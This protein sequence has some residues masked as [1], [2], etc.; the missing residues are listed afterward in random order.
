M[1]KEDLHLCCSPVYREATLTGKGTGVA[2]ISDKEAGCQVASAATE[3]G[4][5]ARAN[6]AR[7]VVLGAPDRGDATFFVYCKSN[8]FSG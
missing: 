5:R 3:E 7:M 4:R 6:P 1:N 2:V 8:T